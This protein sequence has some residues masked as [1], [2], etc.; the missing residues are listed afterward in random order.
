MPET[1]KLLAKQGDRDI[2]IGSPQAIV[3]RELGLEQRRSIV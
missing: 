2:E 3:H 1:Q